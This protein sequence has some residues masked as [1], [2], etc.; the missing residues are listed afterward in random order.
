MVFLL[1]TSER[2]IWLLVLLGRIAAA[3]DSGLLLH[4]EYVTLQSSTVSFH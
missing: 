2:W 4:M 1:F 3:R